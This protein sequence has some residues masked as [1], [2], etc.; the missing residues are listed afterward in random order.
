MLQ[1]RDVNF[2]YGAADV[3]SDVSLDVGDETVALIGA[4][5]AG[6]STLV[7]LLCGIH[8]PRTGSIQWNGEEI[9]GRPAH[10]LVKLG[11]A[12]V[13]EGRQIF[14]NQTVLVNLRLGGYCRNLSIDAERRAIDKIFAQFPRLAERRSQ[15]VGTLSG[16]EQQMVAIGRA[17]MAVPTLLI[18]DEPSMG[19]APQMVESIFEA[20]GALRQ[21]GISILLVEQ[22]AR[23]ALELADRAYVLE[24]GRML[25]NG[26]ADEMARD[27]RILEAYLGKSVAATTA[28]R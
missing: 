19:L 17:L 10:R 24:H 5:G 11:L 13:P 20:L 12:Q 15:N 1:V 2:A 22:N 4:N 14:P 27:A 3:L 6:K 21:D 25:M 16:G 9:G 28:Q 26:P 18:L 7:R 23:L 8:R